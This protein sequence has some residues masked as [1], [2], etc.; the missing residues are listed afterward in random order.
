MSTTILVY[1]AV[2]TN[3]IDY[4]FDFMLCEFSGLNVRLTTDQEQFNGFTGAKINYSTYPLKDGLQLI[5]DPLLTDSTIRHSVDYNDLQTVGKCFYW[6]SRYEEYTTNEFD[7]HQRFLGSTLDYSQPW[8]D[9]YCL[10]IQQ[11]LIALYPTLRFKPRHFQHINT[12]DVDNTWKYAHQSPKRL[13]GSFLKKIVHGQ[14]SEAMEQMA[15]YR[16][17]KED[18]YHTFGYLESLAKRYKINTIFFWLLGD[19]DTYDKNHSWKNKAQQKQI[20]QLAQWATIGIHP[21]YAS[22]TSLKKLAMEVR[23]LEQIHQPSVIQSRQHFI[24]LQFPT[25]YQNLIKEGIQADYTM[26]F[27]HRLGFRAGTA[28]PF[29]WFDLSTNK[30]TTLRVYPF[31]AMDVTLKN[32]LNLT[33][34][35]AIEHLQNLKREIKLVNGT[36]ITLFHQSN[37]SDEWFEWRTVYESIFHDQKN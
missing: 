25:T 11:Q 19:Y 21:S 26:G 6:L 36:F 16:G 31:V 14:F 15:I 24:K 10:A 18:P 13:I 35:E 22:N 27:A 8:V 17:K 1:T 33:P 20:Q 12:H 5:P 28:T 34:Q 29:R 2:K 37:F 4:I 3:R 9:Q 7:D 23:R 32:Y 30:E